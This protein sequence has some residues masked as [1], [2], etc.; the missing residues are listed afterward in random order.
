MQQAVAD[1]ATAAPGGKRDG[2]FFEPTA[3]VDT[4]PAD[5]AAKEEPFGPFAHVY[6]FSS[7]DEAITVTDDTPFGLGSYVFTT[8][9]EQAQRIADQI[10]AGTVFV[11]AVAADE[12]GLCPSAASNAPASAGGSAA[13]ASTRS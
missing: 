4:D 10:Q 13:T 5:E 2:A 7:E 9:P 6:R 8:D 3:L 1:G 11:N 12:P